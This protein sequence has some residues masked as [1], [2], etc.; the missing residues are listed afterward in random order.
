VI[1]RLSTTAFRGRDLSAQEISAH[2]NA[3][4][5][6]SGR[7]RSDDRSIRLD[8]ELAEAKS[9]RIVWSE[10]LEDQVSGIFNEEPELIHHLVARI[11]RAVMSREL[12]R[13]KMQPLPT[14]KACTLLMGAIALMHRLS[15]HD[16]EEAHSYLVTLIDRAPRQ[17]APQ[18]WLANWH[19]LRVQQGWSANPA[20][21]ASKALECTRRAL[22]ADPDNSLA[23]AIDGFVHTNLLKQF[24]VGLQRYES[25]I[26]ANPN[27]PLAWLLKGTLHAFTDRG[28]QAVADTQRALK[29]S[30]LDPHRYF[31]DSLA[32]TAQLTAGC[33]DRALELARRSLRANRSHTSTLRVMTVAQW[34]LGLHDDARSTAREL[35]EL[36]PGLTVS[37][38]L[39]R[40]P[41][42]SFKIGR[43]IADVLGSAG[44]PQ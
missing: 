33:Y 17:A 16:F 25:A 26:S 6:L 10:Q 5:V 34:Q 29:L 23:L 41:S 18:A 43:M 42:A 32:A 9:G 15:V 31:Y 27:D 37:G 44:V 2:L 12:Q 24:D 8:V 14:L 40:A 39:R 19:V 38:Y 7:Y 36:E 22:D 4:Y 28:E 30:P 35:L 20:M 21:D 11:D 13:S 1:S 3:D